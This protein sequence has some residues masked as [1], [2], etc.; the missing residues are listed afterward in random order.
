VGLFLELGKLILKFKR[1]INSGQSI[2]LFNNLSKNLSVSNLNLLSKG[3]IVKIYI[4][5][6]YL[7]L[8]DIIFD[9]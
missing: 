8:K 6:Y 1:S 5:K 7:F 9:I 4:N 2:I 3:N